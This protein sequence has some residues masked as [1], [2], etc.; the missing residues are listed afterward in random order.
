MFETWPRHQVSTGFPR[1]VCTR[2][3]VTPFVFSGWNQTTSPRLSMIN[4]PACATTIFGA[5]KRYPGAVPCAA[6]CTRTSGGFRS[7][8]E[9][10]RRLESGLWHRQDGLEL[11]L[12]RTAEE[13]PVADTRGAVP[14][15]VQRSVGDG[16]RRWAS[17]MPGPAKPVCP[18]GVDPSVAEPAVEPD[19]PS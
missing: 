7:G 13:F 9:R 10:N 4:G 6:V 16:N 11:T 17:G 2:K 18:V 3:S 19:R 15:D 8:R 12:V 14:A 5:R 1:Y